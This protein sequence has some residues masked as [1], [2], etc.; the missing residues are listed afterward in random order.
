MLLTNWK[1]REFL[2]EANKLNP[3]GVVGC[4]FSLQ[5]VKLFRKIKD[6]DLTDYRIELYCPV[7]MCGLLSEEKENGFRGIR[8]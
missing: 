3:K 1:E 7:Y 6:I 4:R 5:S 8:C 2:I